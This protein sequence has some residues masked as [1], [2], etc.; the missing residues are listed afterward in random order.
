MYPNSTPTIVSR[1]SRPGKQS[2]SKVWAKQISGWDGKSLKRRTQRTDE[3]IMGQ[4][5]NSGGSDVHAL[6]LAWNH[7]DLKA[8]LHFLPPSLGRSSSTQAA[9][10]RTAFTKTH[11]HSFLFSV[12]FSGR[13]R[14]TYSG[15]SHCY[16]SQS[17]H[18]DQF[19]CKF[20]GDGGSSSLSHLLPFHHLQWSFTHWCFLLAL[21][22]A[23]G[24]VACLE[25]VSPANHQ[26]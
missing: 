10:A 19:L 21:V 22:L 5:N 15:S 2:I 7:P 1:F 20:V 12:S 16:G 23:E 17:R 6:Q 14:S 25:S 11:I 3:L 26:I 4:E 13:G 8:S 24:R 9:T 18:S